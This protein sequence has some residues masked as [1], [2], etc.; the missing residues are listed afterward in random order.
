MTKILY[1][2][3]KFLAIIPARSGSKG[4][5]DKNIKLFL[6]KPLISY[7]IEAAI[8]S[9]V[10]S[11]IFV[12]TNS[13]RYKKI[14][15]S[16]GASVPFLRPENISSSNSKSTDYIFHAINEFKKIGKTFDFF[17]ILQPTSPIRTKKDIINAADLIIKKDLDSVVSICENDHPK[18]Y[19]FKLPNDL[20]LK[21]I[22][23]N[24][25]RQDFKKTYRINGALYFSKCDSFLIKKSFYTKKSSAYIMPIESSVDI[26]TSFDFNL[27]EFLILKRHTKLI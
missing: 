19:L 4:I 6:G 1:K 15:E 3:K 10:F 8:D 18:E 25:N 2:S 11:E 17:A 12:S 26:D 14:A 13:L 24:F 20:S 9:K 23:S 16:Y 21:G 22:S 7:S 27:A 5:K